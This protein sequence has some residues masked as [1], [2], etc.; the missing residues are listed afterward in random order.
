MLHGVACGNQLVFVV[1]WGCPSGIMNAF[2]AFRWLVALWSNRSHNPCPS[3]SWMSRLVPLHSLVQLSDDPGD[4]HLCLFAGLWGIVA[5]K[6]RI[7]GGPC[8]VLDS[9]PGTIRVH[10]V[11]SNCVVLPSLIG[12]FFPGAGIGFERAS[13]PASLFES[14]L[15]S[16]RNLTEWE[17]IHRLLPKCSAH[18]GS[19]RRALAHGVCCFQIAFL[20]FVPILVCVCVCVCVQ[21]AFVCVC[22]CVCVCAFLSVCVFLQ[23]VLR[24]AIGV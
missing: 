8:Y 22:V 16:R 5:A 21:E 4:L 12:K 9:S 11:T 15:L 19:C 14:A 3:A 24:A 18:R 13:A 23:F 7:L 17:L 10:H 20:P 2:L 6:V 1:T